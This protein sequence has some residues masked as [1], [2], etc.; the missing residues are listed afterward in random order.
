MLVFGDVY[1][2]EKTIG[3]TAIELFAGDA[4]AARRKSLCVYNNG[5]ANVYWGGSDVTT[6]NGFPLLPGDSVIFDFERTD[7]PVSIYAVAAAN[8]TV[9]VAEAC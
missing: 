7:T 6:A 4:R 2:G 1:T 3:T 5:T 8:N 9:R